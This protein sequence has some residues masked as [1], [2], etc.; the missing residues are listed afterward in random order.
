MKLLS[1]LPAHGITRSGIETGEPGEA[2][3]VLD[4]ANKLYRLITDGDWRVNILRVDDRKVCIAK[5]RSHF[6]VS[7]LCLILHAHNVDVI[8][9]NDAPEPMRSLAPNVT[10]KVVTVPL[11]DSVDA[12]ASEVVRLL[13]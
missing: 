3:F 1:I 8:T 2:D 9:V 7:N 5:V 4:V 13:D 12:V 6:A 10:M 11:A